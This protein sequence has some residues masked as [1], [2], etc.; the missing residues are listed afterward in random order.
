[1][2]D[3]TKKED[4]LLDHEWD[5]RKA[6]GSTRLGVGIFL[7]I[8]SAIIFFVG[9]GFVILPCFIILV[10]GLCLIGSRAPIPPASYNGAWPPRPKPTPVI[11]GDDMN[12]GSKEDTQNENK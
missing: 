5:R 4:D 3:M 6:A 1:M 8:L 11:E 2:S 12:D 7:V 9:Q 10:V